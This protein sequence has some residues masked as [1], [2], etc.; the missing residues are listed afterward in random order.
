M[1]REEAAFR[2]QGKHGLDGCVL[3]ASAFAL[4]FFTPDHADDRVLV[5]NLGADLHRTSIA[6]PLI[7][8][9][10]GTAWSLRWSSEDPAYGGRGT[11]AIQ[12]DGQWVFPAESAIV[13]A[14]GPLRSTRPFLVK[15]RR[16][17]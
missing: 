9:P 5:V 13:L 14:P 12:P 7:A 11:P 15:V 17:P 10:A 3:S 1:R 2:A 8:P 4:R 6:D 16:S